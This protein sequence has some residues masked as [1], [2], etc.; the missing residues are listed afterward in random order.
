LSTC[1]LHQN[2]GA[3]FTKYNA[4]EY[5]AGYASVPPI[6]HL[7]AGETMRRYFEPGLDDGKTFVFWGR[8]YNTEGIPGPERSLTWVNQPE[9]LYGSAATVPYRAGQARY[10]NA[11]YT[12]RPDFASGDYREGVV[13]EDANHVTFEFTT[14]YVIGP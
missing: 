3:S 1:G 2:D 4:D 12:Y 7:R 14:P 11:V 13:A 9:K 10:G 6:V 8:N 5:L